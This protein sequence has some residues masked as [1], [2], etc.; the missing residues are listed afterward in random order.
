[1]N[2]SLLSMSMIVS[3]ALQTA[4]EGMG[5]SGSGGVFITM[6]TLNFTTLLYQR[7][8]FRNTFEP[9]N[10]GHLSN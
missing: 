4:E 2:F 6:T 8:G 3:A 10:P 1:M 9:L 5:P 7:F